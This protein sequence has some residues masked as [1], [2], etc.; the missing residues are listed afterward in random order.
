MKDHSPSHRLHFSLSVSLSVSLSLSLSLYH[1]HMCARVI[2]SPVLG[3]PGWGQPFGI[4]A[5]RQRL[6][7]GR[8]EKQ[9][10]EE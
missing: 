6:G 10:L 3:A 8:R 9:G 7:D 2:M 1:N 5:L 4:R